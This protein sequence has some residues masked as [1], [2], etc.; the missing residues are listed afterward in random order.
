[1]SKTKRVNGA[2]R[3]PSKKKLRPSR[4][5]LLLEQVA[6]TSEIVDQWQEIA[7]LW[8]ELDIAH[9]LADQVPL[10]RRY[11]VD[12]LLLV[13]ADLDGCV[14]ACAFREMELNGL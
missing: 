4:V 7:D 6:D 3:Q 10:P 2:Y 5:D 11:L 12:R 14:E 1:M 13:L 8:H 9:L